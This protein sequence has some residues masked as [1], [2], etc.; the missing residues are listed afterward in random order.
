MSGMS[1]VRLAGKSCLKR[2][3]HGNRR[4]RNTHDDLKDVPTLLV[5][6][7]RGLQLRPPLCDQ[8]LK[9]PGTF[10]G[11]CRKLENNAAAMDYD[12][13]ADLDQLLFQARQ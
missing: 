4:I 5:S 1:W 9:S 2:R 10:A 11:E 13:G 3:P 8:P 7:W 12:P 6:C